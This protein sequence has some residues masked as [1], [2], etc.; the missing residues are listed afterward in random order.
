[1]ASYTFNLQLA[2]KIHNVR[3]MKKLPPAGYTRADMQAY[4]EWTRQLLNAHRGANAALE[5]ELEKAINE[6]LAH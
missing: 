6:F 4:A 5:A 3:D 1:M 2:D